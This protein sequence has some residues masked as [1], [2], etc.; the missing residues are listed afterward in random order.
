MFYLVLSEHANQPHNFTNVVF[1]TVITFRSSLFRAVGDPD[2]ISYPDLTLFLT[3]KSEISLSL[4]RGRSGYEINPDL[5][6]RRGG[7]R[8]PKNRFRPFAP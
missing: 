4:G 3:M 1:A 8:S 2:L 7:G 5:E 6:I